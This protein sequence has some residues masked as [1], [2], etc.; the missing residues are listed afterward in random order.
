MTRK[1]GTR[2]TTLNP[3]ERL[4]RRC[5]ARVEAAMLCMFRNRGVKVTTQS[6]K[7]LEISFRVWL[8]WERS[9]IQKQNRP[10]LRIIRHG[11]W[12]CKKNQY[13]ASLAWTLISEMRFTAAASTVTASFSSTFAM[14]HSR[15]PGKFSR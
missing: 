9:K 15:Y 12:T 3:A 5:S 14:M 10:Q 8:S 4:P 7:D 13:L 6:N 11:V 1:Q 2:G